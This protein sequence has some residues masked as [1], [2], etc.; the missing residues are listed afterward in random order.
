MDVATNR[1]RQ[2]VMMN[3]KFFTDQDLYNAQLFIMKLLLLFNDPV[4]GPGSAKLMHVFLGQKSLTPLWELLRRKRFTR[5]HEIVQAGLRY[6]I[7]PT[8]FQ[9]EVA[10]PVFG[11]PIHELGVGHKEGWGRGTVHLL[12]PDQLIPVES[13]R[14]NLD[15]QIHLDFMTHFGHVD[16]MT[17]RNLAPS[18]EEMYMS[19]DDLPWPDQDFDRSV[20]AGCAATCRS[21]R[22]CGRHGLPARLV[23]GAPID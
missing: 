5:E 6:D 1:R 13:V 10:L 4:Y 7:Q 3:R 14:R 2:A 21:N 17:G 11:V 8:E 9:I 18:V 16:L 23:A 15:L 19:D 12:R 20:D 22:A